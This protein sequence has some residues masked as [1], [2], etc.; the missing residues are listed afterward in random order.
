MRLRNLAAALTALLVAL[1]ACAS[2][3]EDPRQASRQEQVAERGE[4]VMPFDLEKTTHRFLPTDD[5][6]RQEV[7][8]D[9]PE[10]TDQIDLVREHLTAEAERFRA[11]DFGDPAS[12]HG[13]Q[14]PGLAELSAGAASIEITYADLP[15]GATLTFHT[16]DPDLIQALH[17]WGEAQVSDHGS[18][19][20]TGT[21]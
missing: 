2:A 17:D 1:G 15:D 19:A 7:V 6:L 20:E 3:D 12:I 14:M 18:H 10:D 9:Q 4:A 8:A 5:G 16:T 11:G 13:D 21:R